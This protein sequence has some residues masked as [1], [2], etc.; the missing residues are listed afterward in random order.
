MSKSIF[1]SWTIWFG[2]CQILLGAVGFLSGKMDHQA[3]LDLIVTGA[4]TIGFRF[5]TSQPIV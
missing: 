4:G 2:I 3:S 5:K 1:A